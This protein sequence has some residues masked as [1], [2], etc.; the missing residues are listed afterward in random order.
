MSKYL[1]MPLIS[2]RSIDIK[3]KKII[4]HCEFNLEW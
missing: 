2:V 1:G 3:K 4:S